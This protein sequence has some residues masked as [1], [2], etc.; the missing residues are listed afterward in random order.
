[1]ETFTNIQEANQRIGALETKLQTEKEARA[2]VQSDLETASAAHSKEKEELNAKHGEELTALKGE[3]AKTVTELTDRLDTLTEENERLSQEAKSADEKAA[4]IVSA[5]GG[6]P[7][8][9]EEE[10]S[11]SKGP[12]NAQE[13]EKLWAEYNA[14]PTSDVKG[15]R[16]F[17]VEK[18]RSR[19]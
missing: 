2:A 10:E 9:A 16:A 17:Y 15:R 6:E 7:V 18:I 19:K 1:M 12:L 4:D 14:I 5:Q 11:A 8:P 3:H 13:E